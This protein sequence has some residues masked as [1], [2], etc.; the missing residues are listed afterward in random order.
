MTVHLYP[1]NIC[2]VFGLTLTTAEAWVLL[3]QIIYSSSSFSLCLSFF[4]VKYVPD[5]STGKE[6]TC[7]AGD[8]ASIPG[9]GRFTGKGIGYPLQYSWASLVVQ[10]VESACNQGD[11]CS[12]PESGRSPGEGNGYPHSILVWRIP[13]TVHGV[14]KSRIRL[15]NFRVQDD[16]AGAG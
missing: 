16:Q 3:A 9:S 5:S 15:S 1:S 14:A 10:L 13:W 2:W 12:V 6:S 4:K 7:N 8:P 11:L